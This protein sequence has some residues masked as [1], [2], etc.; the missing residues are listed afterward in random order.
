MLLQ[1][2]L[3]S[4]LN[5]WLQWIGQRPL[6]EETRNFSVQGFGAT[7]TGGFM[8]KWNVLRDLYTVLVNPGLSLNSL[9]QNQSW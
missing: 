4:Q 1:L 6:Q 9:V 5:T 8:V 2:H 3:H 7:S